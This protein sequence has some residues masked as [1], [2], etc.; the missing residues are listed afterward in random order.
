ML[1]FMRNKFITAKLFLYDIV[2]TRN[3]EIQSNLR[4][5]PII[6][7]GSFESRHD[8]LGSRAKYYC[9]YY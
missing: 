9:Y 4:I 6:L 7:Q 2:V 3:L 8:E 1:A 5:T